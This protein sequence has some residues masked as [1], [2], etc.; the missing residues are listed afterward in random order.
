[1]SLGVTPAAVQRIVGQCSNGFAYD[2]PCARHIFM[3]CSG[4]L[5]TVLLC[6]SRLAWLR[7]PQ[8]RQLASDLCPV[9]AATPEEQTA[10]V[11]WATSSAAWSTVIILIIFALFSCHAI[12]NMRFKLVRLR[13]GARPAAGCGATCSEQQAVVSGIGCTLP[14]S[15][16]RNRPGISVQ[17]TVHMLRDNIVW[18]N[19][20][21]KQDGCCAVA[22]D[23]LLYSRQKAD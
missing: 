10:S 6:T 9:G 13:G 5:Q 11:N 18:P 22:Q 21:K 8:K 3:S 17:P 2:R 4:S 23:S 1:M 7:S 20:L 16:R 19:V 12:A 15:F 14:P